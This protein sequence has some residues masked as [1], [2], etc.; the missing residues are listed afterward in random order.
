MANGLV[1]FVSLSV[2]IA[3]AAISNAQVISF[4]SGNGNVGGLDSKITAI[5]G[6]QTADFAALTST[7]FSNVKGGNAAS[8]LTPLAAGWVSGLGGTSTAKWVGLE[9]RAGDNSTHS[10]SGLYAINFNVGSAMS[11]AQ[12]DLKFSVDD[13]LGGSNNEGLFLDGSAITGS[14]S[15]TDW[16]NQ[17][18]SKS[19]DLGSLSAGQHT[20]Y[21]DVVNS[22]NGPAGL[23]FQG[24]VHN[25]AV[26]E[27]A[28]FA[29]VG[30]GLLGI[31]RR[32]RVKQA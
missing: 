25:Q 23:I 9:P 12:L 14:R 16:N 8:I 19:F 10:E 5:S 3:G 13:Q 17:I 20:L 28:S 29:A 4:Q 6:P 1:R 22:G 2:L 32:R 11:K 7:D 30:I 18:E 21:F 15:F 26:P 24:S 27:P 31:A